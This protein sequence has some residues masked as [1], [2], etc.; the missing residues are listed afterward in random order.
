MRTGCVAIP[1]QG[2]VELKASLGLSE[3]PDAHELQSPPTAG[4]N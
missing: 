2:G 1:A 3:K 4:W